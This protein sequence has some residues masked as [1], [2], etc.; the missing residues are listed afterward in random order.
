ML[1]EL[2]TA[3]LI[4]NPFASAVSDERLVA[5]ERELRRS[6]ELS[7]AVTERR[8]HASEL[9]RE[10]DDVEA[11]FVFGGDGLLNEVLNGLGPKPAVG[12]VPGGG[13][14]VVARSLGIPLEPVEAVRALVS[15]PTRRISVGRANGRR[16]AFAAGIGFDAELVRRVDARGRSTDGRRPGDL[17]FSW[18]AAKL[19]SARRGRYEPVLKI[20]GLGRAAFALVANAHPYTYAGGRPLRV[21]PAARFELGLDVVAPKQV[22]PRSLPRLLRYAFFGGGEAAAD[23]LYAHDL[24]RV[25]VRCDRPLPLQV[26]GE[27]LGDVELVVFEAE[28]DAVSMLAPDV[29]TLRE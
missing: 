20:E 25:E 17:V 24:D 22:T 5:V 23:V 19:L 9:A 6:L 14:N 11:V 26:D 7:L 12:V 4:V 3:A 18:E 8:G 27:D 29:G 28:R 10:L 1:G 2:K 13:K 15:A 16:F 21:A